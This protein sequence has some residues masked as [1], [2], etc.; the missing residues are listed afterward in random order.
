MLRRV[1]SP[2]SRSLRAVLAW[3]AFA[4][5]T[6]ATL[7]A[8]S[9]V[10][11]EAVHFE[12]DYLTSFGQ[13]VFVVGDTPELGHNDVRYAPKLVPG[14]WN[15]D[16]PDHLLWTL[17][18][19]IPQGTQFTWRFVLRNDDVAQYKNSANGTYL[20]AVA[21]GQTSAPVPATRDWIV[22]DRS[23]NASI[24]LNTS[25]GII[26][27]PLRAVPGDT[28]L[29]AAVWPNQPNGPGVNAS[30]SGF[31]IDTPRH[32]IL[33]RAAA[34]YDYDPAGALD[35][36]G[37]KETIAVPSQYI[38]STRT[39]DGV[40]GRGAQVWLPRG[41]DQQ[42]G[43]RYPVLYM[44]DGQNVFIPGG[45][46][47]TW[48]A[49]QTAAALIRA[50]RV[51]ELII[52]GIDNSSQRLVEYNPDW[53]G[54]V[55]ANY[56]RFL[57]EELIPAIDARYRTLSGP[58]N[59]GICGSSFGGVASLSAAVAHPGVFGQVAALSTSFW[60]TDIETDLAAGA[61]PFSTRLYLD[62]GDINDDG[63]L[64]VAARDLLLD[65]GRVLE[66]NLFFQIGFNQQHNEAAWSQRFDE[67]LVALFPIT[68]LDAGLDTLPLPLVGDLDGDCDVDLVDLSTLLV[69]FGACHADAPY[70]P[71]SDIDASGCVDLLDLSELLAEFG[72]V[73]P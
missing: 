24:S 7:A 1:Q 66:D 42:P 31:A 4:G 48:A 65:G 57:V 70:V 52:V 72:I 8:G 44:H 11:R 46:Y 19:A 22:F 27:L 16:E 6:H 12:I 37:R 59:T 51:S 56:N 25:N 38:L 68:D 55:N 3:A 30:I 53:P 50:A 39:I 13:S 58:Q 54:S 33:N 49:E 47:G 36:A 69:A 60:A 64:T 67:V 29:R 28:G 15:P 61:I 14:E 43:R 35:Q 62:A 32:V 45:P 17:E 26:S 2:F 73:C 34:A 41:Y 5:W 40:T 18:V 20:T 9:E 63:D 21:N 10:P 23:G 71:V